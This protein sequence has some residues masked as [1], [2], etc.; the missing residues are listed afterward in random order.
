VEFLS[1]LVQHK[2][3]CTTV[4]ATR[5]VLANLASRVNEART[6]G[7]KRPTL[8]ADERQKNVDALR[9][10]TVCKS[11]LACEFSPSGLVCA[12]L[13]LELSFFVDKQPAFAHTMFFYGQHLSRLG[14]YE[15]AEV[16][17]TEAL[18]GATQAVRCKILC[19]LGELATLTRR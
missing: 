16:A 14:L 4:V 1:T 7:K 5:A 13:S 12:R 19:E 3:F 9:Q 11:Q 18:N 15:A 6:S 2:A 17:L 10:L 8:T